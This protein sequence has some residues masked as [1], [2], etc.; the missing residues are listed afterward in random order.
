MKWYKIVGQ[1]PSPYNQRI[2][3][4]IPECYS[5]RELK[6]LQELRGWCNE[7]STEIISD[8]EARELLRNL[9]NHNINKPNYMR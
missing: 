9:A 5:P 6:S 3:H 1:R 4:L 8:N 2:I 7:V